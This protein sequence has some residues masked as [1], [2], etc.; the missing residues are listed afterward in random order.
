[1]ENVKLFDKV[2]HKSKKG[3]VCCNH[4]PSQTCVVEFD[5]K[6]A[7]HTSW[8]SWEL[9]EAIPQPQEEVKAG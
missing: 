3:H 1:M 7:R 6:P 5:G 2:V 9:V 8:I 4:R